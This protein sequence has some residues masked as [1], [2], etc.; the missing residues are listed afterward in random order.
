MQAKFI[1]ALADDFEQHGAAAIAAIR[2]KDPASYIRAIV[3]LMPK[4]LEVKRPLEE[5]SDEEL[6]SCV[7]ALSAFVRSEGLH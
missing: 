2:E 7:A 5:L 3:S 1:S 4:E 6:A